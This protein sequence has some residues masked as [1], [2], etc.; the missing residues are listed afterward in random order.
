M[1]TFIYQFF[2]HSGIGTELK[3]LLAQRK[4]YCIKTRGISEV[5]KV[6][7][8][9]LSKRFIKYNDSQCQILTLL[10][11]GTWKG[12]TVVYGNF[13]KKPERTLC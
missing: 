3:L 7:N 2:S 1:Y 11:N 6:T 4:R 9:S 12:F 8:K 13:F 10:V 5:F